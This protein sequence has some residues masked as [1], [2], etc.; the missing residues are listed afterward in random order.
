MLC[1]GNLGT[2]YDDIIINTPTPLLNIHVHT[3]HITTNHLHP[4]SLPA[5]S[6]QLTSDGRWLTTTDKDTVRIWDATNLS[7]PVKQFTVAYPLEAASY[8]PAKV[9]CWRQGRPYCCA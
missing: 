6:P 4:L 3:H 1:C 2:L 7:T 9:G 8:C 5:L